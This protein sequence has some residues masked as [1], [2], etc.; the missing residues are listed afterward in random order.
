LRKLFA[1]RIY[2]LPSLW[3]CDDNG[4]HLS[5]AELFFTVAKDI[6]TYISYERSSGEKVELLITRSSLHKPEDWRFWIVEFRSMNPSYSEIGRL[7]LTS[8]FNQIQC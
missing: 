1:P 5:R 2:I 6:A 8:D 7:V 3:S 4:N